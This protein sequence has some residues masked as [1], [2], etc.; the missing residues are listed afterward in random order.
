MNKMAR[1]KFI[2]LLVL[3]TCFAHSAHADACR[4]VLVLNSY[5]QDHEWS[6]S[7]VDSIGAVLNSHYDDV[8]LT[9][10]YLSAERIDNPA[11]WIDRI[12]LLF[13]SY[14][15][16]RPSAVII[17]SDEAWMAYRASSKRDVLNDIPIFLCAVKPHSI[18]LDDYFQKNKELS[19]S[20][21]KSTQELMAE[22]SATGVIQDI[23]VEGY[24]NLMDIVLPSIKSY[25]IITDNS[26]HG[27][28]TKLVVENY[29]LKLRSP[30]PI[31][32]LCEQSI[33]TDSLLKLFPLIDK[34][35]GVLM[36][37]WFADDSNYAYSKSYVYDKMCTDIKS[38]IF[39]TTDLGVEGNVVGG[40]YNSPGFWG[41]E[42][43]SMVVE[44][45]EDGMQSYLKPKIYKDETCNI[46]WNVLSKYDI[47]IDLLP[48]DTN[49][50]NRPESIIVKYSNYFIFGSV[51]LFLLVLLNIY[52]IRNNIKFKKAHK[53]KTQ[54]IEELNVVNIDLI[55]TQNKLKEAL[56]K[57]EKAD[58]LKSAF[59]SSMEHEIRTSLNL[60]VG[61]STIIANMDD[62]DDIDNAANQ[63]QENSE[64]L[65]KL[66]KDIL[67]LSQFESGSAEFN[68]DNVDIN[69]MVGDLIPQFNK[70]LKK[71]VL[72]NYV[73]P[74]DKIVVFTDLI[75]VR[76]VLCVMIS[77]AVKFTDYDG[78]IE[79]GFY[80]VDNIW[81]EFYVKDNGVGIKEDELDCVF[82]Y[83][84]KHDSYTVGSGLGLSVAKIIVNTLN[85]EIGVDS[86]Y[87]VGSRFWFRIKK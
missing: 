9:V 38:P 62:K 20:D 25:T 48:S 86:K 23:N 56:E 18:S 8:E 35:S 68:Y 16:K 19:L 58:R 4:K 39:V 32:Y 27:I 17:I 79:V 78:V 87:G 46:N 72:I 65:L 63:I 67:D 26:F 80:E 29:L 30:L 49:F 11:L 37:S 57:A 3:I 40:F 70:G 10:E 31:E 5:S 41:K 43:A 74:K 1:T 82:D 15:D 22:F 84:Y 51:A 60:I 53:L 76:Q 24:F 64:T 81:V 71:G 61:F 77:N 34:K 36:T 85:G 66:I 75:R 44:S 45:F 7:I 83:F 13:D 28:Y 42:V 21:F 55:N 14:V 2:L 52:I 50:I 6:N 73:K 69:E 59:I 12:D 54:A 33:T 47:E